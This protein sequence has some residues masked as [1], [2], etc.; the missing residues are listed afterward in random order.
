MRE[1]SLPCLGPHGFHRVHYYEWGEP[2][3]GRVLICVHGLT[4]NGRDFDSLARA[5]SRHY[6]VLC[7]DI[8]G[9]GRSGWLTHKEDYG[10]PLYCSDMATLIARSGAQTVDWVGTSMGGIIGMLLASQPGAPIGKLVVND[11]GAFIPA[12]AVNRL[13]TYVGKD[14]SFASFE[15]AE[16]YLR[17]VSAPFGPL[18]DEQWRHLAGSSFSQRDNGQW[19]LVYDPAI[20]NAFSGPPVDVDL[21]A[22]WDRI[23]RPTLVLRGADSDLLLHK[24]AVE[25]TTRGPKP[26]V[27]EFAGVGHA[28]MLMTEDQIGVVQEFLLSDEHA[29]TS[30]S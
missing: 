2:D 1:H 5:M 26:R 10:Y 23:R 9:R 29:V 28:P 30:N 6:R 17:F 8:V 15:E 13:K 16:G 11:V 19:G 25:M 14:P 3:N 20:A 22:Y 27:V 12:T 18:T 4:R 7:P 21:W 24:T